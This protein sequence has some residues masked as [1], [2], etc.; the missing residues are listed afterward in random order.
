MCRVRGKGREPATLRT[1]GL[2]SN[3]ISRRASSLKDKPIATATLELL[4]GRKASEKLG[5]KRKFKCAE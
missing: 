3:R 5:G 2:F 1:E 4:T